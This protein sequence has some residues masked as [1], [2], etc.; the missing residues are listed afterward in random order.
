MSTLQTER[1]ASCP[2]VAWKCHEKERTARATAQET[3]L[4]DYNV[5]YYTISS[6]LIACKHNVDRKAQDAERK[7][8]KEASTSTKKAAKKTGAKKKTASKAVK[9]DELKAIKIP[10]FAMKPLEA[11]RWCLEHPRTIMF[12]G[13]WWAVYKSDSL[14]SYLSVACGEY[15][16]AKKMRS[17][18]VMVGPAVHNDDSIPSAISNDVIRVET[19]LPTHTNIMKT[20][21]DV[22]SGVK[23]RNNITVPSI[24]DQG[25]VAS[26][27]AGLTRYQ[28]ENTGARSIV[29]TKT[30]DLDYFRDETEKIANALPGVK[31]VRPRH[32]ID[33]VGGMKSAIDYLNVITTPGLPSNLNA[34]MVIVVGASGTG[35]SMVAYAFASARKWRV[36]DLHLGDIQG[37]FVGES[38]EKWAKTQDFLGAIDNAVIVLDELEKQVA[39]TGSDSSGTMTRMIGSFLTWNQNRENRALIVATANNIVEL[40]QNFP[41]LFRPGRVDKIFFVDTPDPLQSQQIKELKSKEYD[42]PVEEWPLLSNWTGAEIEQ[43]A[44]EYARY[45]AVGTPRTM[46]DLSLGIIPLATKNADQLEELRGF[47]DQ[48]FVDANTGYPYMKDKDALTELLV[49]VARFDHTF[50]EGDDWGP[51]MEGPSSAIPPGLPGGPPITTP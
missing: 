19:P 47:A 46:A 15:G 1:A 45:K 30:L 27:C 28:V 26:E 22:L 38:E 20:L 29:A 4:K 44:V 51:G 7:A 8:E 41:E 2:L 35:K 9:P 16:I 37:R 36:I 11:V 48:Q 21:T 49:N 24:A 40:S 6:G 50:D 39:G 18:F 13:D 31:V 10:N 34:S 42:I 23:G 12:F 25:L 32:T 3:W 17:M 14:V 33:Q 5:W 43:L